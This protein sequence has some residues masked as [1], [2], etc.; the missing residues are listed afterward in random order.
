MSFSVRY[1]NALR[2][3]TK[4]ELDHRAQRFVAS[5][6]NEEW[7]TVVVLPGGM[8]SELSSLSEPWSLGNLP[9]EVS[10]LP[11]VL[12]LWIGAATLGRFV[13]DEAHLLA[14]DEQ[15]VERRRFPCVA[16]GALGAPIANPYP[17]L[18]RRLR[19]RELN[20]VEFGFD[21]R[22]SLLWGSELLHYFLDRLDARARELG[23]RSPLPVLLLAHSQGG[24]VAKLFCEQRA[25]QG[26]AA[27]ERY[28]TALVCAGTPFL[29]TVDH[30]NRYFGGVASPG[31]RGLPE[32]AALVAMKRAKQA[33]GAI[34]SRVAWRSAIAEW[35]SMVASMPGLWHL[36]TPSPARFDAQLLAHRG[37]PRYP[38][39]RAEGDEALDFFGDPGLFPWLRQYTEVNA[40]AYRYRQD[41]QAVTKLPWGPLVG[42][43]FFARGRGGPGTC[44][45]EFTVRDERDIDIDPLRPLRSLA[46]QRV[47]VARDAAHDGT[48]PLWSATLDAEQGLEHTVTL[49][50]ATHRQIVAERELIARVE[51]LARGESWTPGVAAT[52]EAPEA[53]ADEPPTIESDAELTS[54]AEGYFA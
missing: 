43:L 40:L 31:L 54:W 34:D 11:P 38:L 46:Q 41:S 21:W 51:A 44:E 25:V 14:L 12:P 32:F 13:N 39:R 42:R 53:P 35:R 7:P 28:F 9:G 4:A 29:G 8:G 26:S 3:L 22:R 19:A 52:S 15:G 37:L 5:D 50:G 16:T 2:R 49:E 45:L 1:M 33:Q 36:I 18:R 24:L 47:L 20:C 48:V 17:K 6:Y 27:V 30:A 23:R 10:E